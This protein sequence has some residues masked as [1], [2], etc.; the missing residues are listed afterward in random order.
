M[1]K[2]RSRA[3]VPDYFAIGA[4]KTMQ[5]VVK[6]KIEECYKGLQEQEVVE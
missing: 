2:S 6:R 5:G 4:G 1:S 3:I